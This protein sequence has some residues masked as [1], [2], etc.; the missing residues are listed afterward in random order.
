MNSFDGGDSIAP[1]QVQPQRGSYT[2]EGPT[3]AR[4]GSKVR[5]VV[6]D[7]GEPPS[8]A[9]GI[10][11][12][13]ASGEQEW[14]LSESNQSGEVEHVFDAPGTF[15]LEAAIQNEETSLPVFVI[16]IE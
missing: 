10:G 3:K 4:V 14:I 1:E 9:V 2:I 12:K 8:P 13:A 16:V 15:Q 6:L 5:F 11:L 7:T